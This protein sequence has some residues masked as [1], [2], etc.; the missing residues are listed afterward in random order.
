MMFAEDT[1]A[2]DLIE[3]YF[4]SGILDAEN[5]EMDSCADMD[6][7]TTITDGVHENYEELDIYIAEYAKGWELDRLMKTDLAILR[8]AVFEILYAKKDGL[9]VPPKVAINEAVELCKIYS[10][11]E[12]PVFVNGVLG[13]IAKVYG[14]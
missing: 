7:V 9:S 14:I 12:S 6:Y 1:A 4:E 8:M 3:R 11:D 13:Q 10:G 5:I 2:D